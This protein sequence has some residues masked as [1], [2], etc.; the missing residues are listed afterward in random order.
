M[1]I[2][3]TGTAGFIGFHAA[4]HFLDKGWEVFGV[5]NFS[6]YYSV[7]LK[8]DREKILR[9]RPGYRSEELDICDHEKLQS[10]FAEEK[11]EVVLHLAAQPGVR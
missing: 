3:I 9:G 1:K 11:P 7:G 10:V 6:S 4:R 2:L 8:R 5:D